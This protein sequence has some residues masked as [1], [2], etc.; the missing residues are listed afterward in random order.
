M[1]YCKIMMLSS[2]FWFS[3]KKRVS[4]IW[5]VKEVLIEMNVK[6]C[7]QTGAIEEHNVSLSPTL[8]FISQGSLLLTVNYIYCFLFV[9]LKNV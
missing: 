8:S 3:L 5:E 9:F 4:K 2:L 6:F 7:Y 1:F